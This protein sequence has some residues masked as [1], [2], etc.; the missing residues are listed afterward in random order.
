MTWVEMLAVAGAGMAAGV[1]NAVVG[2]GTLVTF[3]VLV[4]LGYPPVVATMSNAIGL[5]PGGASAVWGYRR[6]LSGQRRLVVRLVPASLLG[7]IVGATLLVTLPPEAFRAVVP[8][9]IALALVLVLVQPVVHRAVVRRQSRPAPA[10]AHREPG[11][12]VPAD[13]AHAAVPAPGQDPHA[14]VHAIGRDHPQHPATLPV[15]GATPGRH[16]LA[17]VA[18]VTLVGLAGVYGGYFAGAQGILL[19]GVLGL[20]VQESMHRINAVKNLLVGVVN[21]VAAATYTLTAFD[22]VAWEVV[23]LVAAGSV[24]G[25]ALGGRYGRRLPPVVLRGAVV[26]LGVA[27]IWRIVAG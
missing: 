3:P 4:W 11:D 22:D 15:P 23:G 9:L 27:A 20:L 6:E 26:V 7:A 2:S 19:L 13:A 8:V 10:V 1:I 16:R 14:P 5:V 24:L 18:L 25:G 17:V 21:A 12:E